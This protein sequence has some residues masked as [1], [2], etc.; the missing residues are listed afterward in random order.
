MANSNK[1][2]RDYNGELKIPKSKRDRMIVSRTK[3]REIIRNWFT[4]NKPDYP[5][6]FWI[7]G[8]HK[9]RLN[10]RTKD[11][12]CDQDDG[13]YINRNPD[14]SVTGTTLQKWI[15]TALTGSTS[16][17]PAHKSRCVRN[18]YKANSLGPY[19]LDYPAYYKTEQMDHPK[20]AV[21]N[22]ELEES[23]PKEFT[24]W[25]DGEIATH[26]K[27]LRRSIKYLKGWA[28]HISKNHKMP[29]GLT[30]TVL[31]CEHF[32]YTKDRDDEALYNTLIGIYDELDSKWECIMPATPN[33]DLLE[34]YDTIFQ[35]NFMN[36]LDRLIKDAKKALDQ[37]SNHEA[38][39]LWKKHLG[40]RF[41]LEP[42]AVSQGSRSA[43]GSLVGSNKPY[44]NGGGTIS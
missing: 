2:F 18:F 36:A 24:D 27:Q 17:T 42:K 13:V 14:D 25:L 8:S 3:A 37:E 35:I 40:K 26:G 10:I 44:Y 19:H 34:R 6:S 4:K 7:Q 41:P 32:K 29:N 30:L 23:D 22:S 28:N 43:L 16:T 33:D 5:V 15:V 20:L 21:K 39:K 31:A 9:N 12:D 11:E 1:Q 38:T